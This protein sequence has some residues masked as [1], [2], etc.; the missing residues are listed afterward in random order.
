MSPN[1]DPLDEHRRRLVRADGEIDAVF[2]QYGSPIDELMNRYGRK[3]PADKD[4]MVLALLAKV[5][6]Y[7]ARLKTS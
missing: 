1:T 2:L 7:R 5:M 4:V 3:N 6:M